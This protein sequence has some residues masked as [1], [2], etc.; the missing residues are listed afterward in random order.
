MTPPDRQELVSLKARVDLVEL[1]RHSG[2]ELKKKGKNWL[3][4]CPFHEDG[5]ASLSV[6]GKEG[7]WNC[8]GCEAGGDHVSFLQLREK[9]DFGAAVERLRALAGV[10][11]EPIVQPDMPKE[12]A[13]GFKRPSCWS[14]WWSTTRS[15]F[16]RRRRP[17]NTEPARAGFSRAVGFV[18]AGLLRWQLVGNA[19]G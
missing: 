2:L 17:S 5:Q 4:R 16:A 15:V 8:F 18:P 12:L 7:L 9:L 14:G 11:P 1:V 19:A 6:N 10:L 13:G 3:G